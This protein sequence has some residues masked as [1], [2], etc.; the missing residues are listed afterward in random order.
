MKK[1]AKI[2]DRIKPKHGNEV[3]RFESEELGNL[4]GLDLSTKYKLPYGLS[5]STL[6]MVKHHSTERE[7]QEVYEDLMLQLFELNPE[8]LELYHRT[9]G[10]RG[11][12]GYFILMGCLSRY[13][14][15]DIEFFVSCVPMHWYGVMVLNGKPDQAYTDKRILANKLIE[16][17]F[18][19]IDPINFQISPK[20]LEKVLD[21]LK[22]ES[23]VE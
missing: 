10:M 7:W 4:I 3:T 5:E 18:N 17:K 23:I 15:E 14:I 22:L 1:L 19:V 20:N 13:S 12:N 9:Y 16:D 2:I 21:H 8:V 6:M 11:T